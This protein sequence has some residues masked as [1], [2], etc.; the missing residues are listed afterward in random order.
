MTRNS[1]VLM[2]AGGSFL[3]LA[4]AFL[5]QSFGYAPCKLCLWQRWPHAAAIAA[6][7]AVLFVPVAAIALLGALSTFATAALGIYHTGVEQTWWPGPSGCTGG[8]MDL[9]TMSG[10]DLLSME[11]PTGVVMCDEIVWSLFG[12]SM[13]GWNAVISLV[14]VLLWLKAFRTPASA[15]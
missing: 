3:L 13:A 10:A 8:G 15:P 9:G 2:A 5:F 11:G 1:W 12:L 7:V 14:L 4:G 6:G